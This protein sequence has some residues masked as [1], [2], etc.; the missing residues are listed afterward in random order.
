MRLSI[1]ALLLVFAFSYSAQTTDANGLKQ[2]YWKK[3]DEKTGKLVY[4]GE[5]KDDKPEGKFKY[6]YPNDS[7]QAIMNFSEGGKVA[8]A[9]L[10]HPTGKIMGK[11]K[12]ISEQKDSIWL[13]YDELGTLLSKENYKVGKKDG[14]SYVY[15]PEG[16]VAEERNFKDG[17][18]HGE[19]KLYFDGKKV[20]GKGNYVN[21]KLE[22]KCAY[23]YPNGVEV[24][25]GFYKNGAKE[26][27]W[28]YKDE[29]GKIKEKELYK[30]GH[31]A[32][33][34]EAD[35]YFSKNKVPGTGEKKTP[36]NKQGN[37][38]VKSTGK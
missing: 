19:F 28:I 12:Y 20:R 6:Y 33:Q 29:K 22:G 38:P 31:K 27:P 37:K 17:L 8:H 1:L 10:F 36:D 32:S 25:S 11:G 34:K 2:G 4:E 9:K 21:D 35:A 23:F 3:K 18:Q 7:V 24:A 30:N 14:T 26:G 16:L 15:L 5:F 13:Y